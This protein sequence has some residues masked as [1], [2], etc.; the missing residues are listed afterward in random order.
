M[1]D[2]TATA[3]SRT[4]VHLRVPKRVLRLMDEQLPPGVVAL[5]V[6][7]EDLVPEFI[8]LPSAEH[9][10][11]CPVTGLKPATLIALLKRAGRKI[12]THHLRQPGAV[13]GITLIHRQSLI[14]YV[15]SLPPPPAFAGEGRESEKSLEDV[16]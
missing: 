6:A 16:S 12:R 15:N 11:V 7:P 4:S 5:L 14:D 1:S 3:D 13:K 10:R 9:E 2:R 8:R